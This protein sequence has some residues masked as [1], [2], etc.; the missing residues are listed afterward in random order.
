MLTPCRL[1]V[2]SLLLALAAPLWAEDPPATSPMQPTSPPTINEVGGKTLKQWIAD[3]N[4][5]DP[6]SREEAIRAIVVFGDAAKEAVPALVRRL[7][8]K[9]VSP[10]I[11]AVMA[12]GVVPI[13]K[14]DLP[15]VIEALA[16]RL[17]RENE[18]Q[19]SVR[20]QAA[21]VLGSKG[22]DAKAALAALIEGTRDMASWEI[23]SACVAA[24][25]EVAVDP[26]T[27]PDPKAIHA[28]LERL[29]YPDHQDPAAEVRYETILSLGDM[30]LPA[31]NE[32][33]DKVL[34]SLKLAASD[35]HDAVVALWG[36]VALMALDKVT[37]KD[38]NY[39]AL[40]L[41]SNEPS[42]T[43]MHAARAVGTLG[44][45]AKTLIPDLID[46]LREK[47]YSLV[48]A[49]CWALGRMGADAGDKAVA[50]LTEL[51]DSKEYPEPVHQAAADALDA[52]KK[53]QKK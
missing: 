22:K 8:D 40:R 41:K 34:K 43:R 50:A 16:A 29:Q 13:D 47:D 4:H 20:Y 37:D 14:K 15:A 7:E 39:I 17:S 52:I 11:K 46:L 28:L 38:L 31:D 24:L 6:S 9:D 21:V 23:R 10:R 51:K 1:A 53:P 33:Q 25:P 42:R 19:A 36:H 44:T 30:G 35:P 26:K 2:A 3:L 45:K 18:P 48:L 12:L 27:G 32:L 49:G 5:A